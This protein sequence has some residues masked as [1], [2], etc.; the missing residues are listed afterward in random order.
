LKGDHTL[1]AG[2]KLS[3]IL[4]VLPGLDLENAL[5]QDWP[6]K[7]NFNS[8]VPESLN[9]LLENFSLILKPAPWKKNKRA[10]SKELGFLSLFTDSRGNYW[11]SCSRGFHT[12]LNES[13]A[14]LEV[15][16]DELGEH[17]D[18]EVKHKLNQAYRRLSEYLG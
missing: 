8:T 5:N 6:R 17:V 4:T 14:S 3:L 9:S 10:E 12:A 13:V 16:I 15:L 7:K 2:E 18:M 1:L 11:F